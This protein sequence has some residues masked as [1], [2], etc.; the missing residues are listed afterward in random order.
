MTRNLY[1]QN[2]TPVEYIVMKTPSLLFLENC[3][4]VRIKL[5]MNGQPAISDQYVVVTPSGQQI[6]VFCDFYHRLE[7]SYTYLSPAAINVIDTTTLRKLHNR[8]LSNVNVRLLMAGGGQEE[9]VLEQLSFFQNKYPLVVQISEAVGYWEPVNYGASSFLYLGFQPA[10]AAPASTIDKSTNPIFG[11]RAGGVDFE[12]I[13]RNQ[14]A[15]S[16]AA[17]FTNSTAFK[18]TSNYEW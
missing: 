12:F 10:Q 13:N 14:L 18:G 17:L 6:T 5:L 16:Y 11:Y 3:E 4:D 9:N 7:V 15:K 1:N 8:R 2:K